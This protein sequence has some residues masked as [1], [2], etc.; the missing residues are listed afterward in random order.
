MDQGEPGKTAG[1][2]LTFL[3]PLYEAPGPV[4]SVYLDSS[5]AEESGAQEIDLRWR[6]A[7]EQLADAGAD[8]ATLDAIEAVVGQHRDVPGRT[9]QVV[10]AKEGQVL[11]DR[12]LAQPPR[13]EIARWSALPHVMPLLAQAGSVVPHVIVLADRIGA[14][15]TAVGA[16]RENLAIREVTGQKEYARKVGAGGWS[17]QR[18]QHTAE[19]TWKSNAGQV[20]EQVDQLVRSVGAKVLVAAGDV[21]AL[22][23]LRNQLSDGSRDLLVE[24]DEGGAAPGADRRALDQAIE[25]AVV[26]SLATD[27]QG[28]VERF[29]QERGRHES[30]AEGLAETIDALRRAQ[31]D[32]LIVVDDP[33]AEGSLWVGSEPTLLSESADQLRVLGA[34]RPTQ[35]RADAALVRAA[36]GSG[37]SLLVAAQGQVEAKDG[38][39]AILRYADAATP[40]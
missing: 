24:V 18:F 20:A 23:K 4:A 3:S 5:R 8:D 32:T 21:R 30:A 16:N 39:G 11:L 40:S 19:E 13:R 36:V 9:G 35:D 38:V 10:F 31:V 34:D 12:A 7:R 37:A 2:D 15:V 29:N 14:E 22:E 33:S 17:Q 6:S 25:E 28:V 26:R 27:E 1:M